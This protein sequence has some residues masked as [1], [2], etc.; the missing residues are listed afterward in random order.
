MVVKSV[1]NP[2]W[3][4]IDI[5]NVQKG[6]QDTWEGSKIPPKL[7]VATL[8]IS[9]K[10]TMNFGDLVQRFNTTYVESIPDVTTLADLFQSLH[11]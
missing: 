6:I 9:Q 8:I 11:L 1:L 4:F 7:L 5:R 2:I 3:G 10:R